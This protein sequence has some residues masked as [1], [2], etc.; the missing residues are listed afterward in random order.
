MQFSVAAVTGGVLHMS[1]GTSNNLIEF[2]FEKIAPRT[3]NRR[4]SASTT[5]IPTRCGYGVHP[6]TPKFTERSSHSQIG[7]R[8]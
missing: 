1:R 6:F 2:K 5:P 4:M 3:Y 7:N 8:A